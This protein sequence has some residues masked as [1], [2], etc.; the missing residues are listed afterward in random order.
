MLRP[1]LLVVAGPNGAGK[2]TITK[3]LRTESRWSEGAESFIG[4]STPTINAARVAARVQMGGHDVPI[5]K[6]V[7]RY[8]RSIAN[9]AAAIALSDRTYVYDNSIDDVEASLCARTTNRH[10]DFTD[11]R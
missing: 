9:L 3:R 8:E 1:N 11:L 6:I 4:T 10:P 2:T 5:T 7:H